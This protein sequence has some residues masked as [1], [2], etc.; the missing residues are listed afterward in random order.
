L[1]VLVGVV[2]TLTVTPP[3]SSGAA[4]YWDNSQGGGIARANL[5]GSGIDAEFLPFSSATSV[6][7]AVSGPYIYVGSVHGVIE[8]ARL[9]GTAI[10]PNFI[11]FEPTDVGP[12]YGYEKIGASLAIG[13]GYIYWPDYGADIGRASIAGN[14]D[15]E[16]RFI[17]TEGAVSE[18]AVD[19]GHI[20]WLNGA[21]SYVGRANLG[22]SDV[23]PRLLRLEKPVPSG[24]AV[25]DGHI[26]WP[27][28]HG[29]G[30]ANLEGR[31]I[32]PHFIV[33]L[34]RGVVSTVAVGGG[35]IYW[36]STEQPSSGTRS[37]IGRAKIG[38]RGVDQHLINVTNRITGRI[39]A[40]ALGPSAGPTRH[41]KAR[42]MM[43]GPK[44]DYDAP[45]TA[46][47][48]KA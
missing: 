1:A 10:D 41:R 29:I 23:E 24:I 16:G 4:L 25:A 20:Y 9:D 11:E 22:G 43:T 42:Q 21:G 27:E 31:Q 17:D 36:G 32:N 44:H 47:A 46:P 48:S 12:S 13:D 28:R 40:D 45:P 5:N 6:G 2:A 26:Y 8:R 33:G 38:G 3:T 14:G 15:I 30:C 18:V 35:Y 7:L 37:W 34:N 39:V 19:A